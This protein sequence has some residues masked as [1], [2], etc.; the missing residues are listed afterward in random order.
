MF[1]KD[2]LGDIKMSDVESYVYNLVLWVQDPKE[3]YIFKTTRHFPDFCTEFLW[4]L[5]KV[6]HVLN[7]FLNSWIS[8]HSFFCLLRRSFLIKNV[9]CIVFLMSVRH[10]YLYMELF[11]RFD[12]EFFKTFP[13]CFSPKENM[14]VAVEI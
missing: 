4:F 9:S 10:K 1:V 11:L 8:S 7:E 12:W 14:H 13:A 5:E 6:L 3:Y 2:G